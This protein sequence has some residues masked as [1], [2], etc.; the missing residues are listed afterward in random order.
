MEEALNKWNSLAS[1][2]NDV[3]I[4]ILHRLP[5]YSLFYCKYVC[6]SWNRLIMDYNNH[7]VLPRTLAGFFYD[8]D[9]GHRR[10]TSVTGEHPS[11]SFL[12]FTLVNVVVLD[13]YNVLI[14]CWYRGANDLYRY[15]VC[16]TKKFKELSPGIHSIGEARLGFDPIASSHFHVIECIEEEQDDECMGVDIYSSKTTALIC[17]ESKWEPNTYVTF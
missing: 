14:L 8:F 17:K 10:Y 6:R 1:L 5:A 16:T 4:E 9:Q 11:L 2:T 15:V 12:P 7:K 13:I 3:I